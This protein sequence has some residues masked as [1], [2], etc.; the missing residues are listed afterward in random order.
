MSLGKDHKGFSLVELIVVV[1]IVGILAGASITLLGHIRHANNDKVVKTITTALSKQQAQT[2]SKQTK[3]YLYIY[4]IDGEY[5][6]C[7]STVKLEAIDGSVLSKSAGTSLGS[8]YSIYAED[9]AVRWL[10]TGSNFIRV[11]YKRDGSFDGAC[12]CNTIS[13]ETPSITTKI[14]LIKTSGKHV[15]SVE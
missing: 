3:P 9:G 11:A 5:Y 4:Q 6:I 14:K 15:I 10:V 1:G 8:G 2:M 12:N 7:Q 13:V